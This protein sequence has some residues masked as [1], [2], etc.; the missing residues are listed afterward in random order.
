MGLSFSV[1]P[2]FVRYRA[3]WTTSSRSTQPTWGIGSPRAVI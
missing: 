1:A 3:A 2:R